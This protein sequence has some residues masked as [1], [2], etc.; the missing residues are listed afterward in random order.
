M[1]T[2]D[3]HIGWPLLEGDKSLTF[4]YAKKRIS[5]DSRRKGSL[6]N[7][8]RHRGKG[9]VITFAPTGAGKGVSTIIPTLLTYPGSMIVIDPKGEN[10]HVTARYRLEIGQRVH[11]LDPFSVV[12]PYRSTVRIGGR[13]T[14]VLLKADSLNPLDFPAWSKFTNDSES[15]SIA[16]SLAERTGNNAFWDNLATMLLTGLMH[17]VATS[18]DFPKSKRTLSSVIKM[19]YS[20]HFTQYLHDILKYRPID[21]Y[22][23]RAFEG[24]QSAGE[25]KTKGE[26]LSFARGYLGALAS[27]TIQQSVSETTIDIRGLIAGS[28]ITIYVVF[29]AS[30]LASFNKL[31]R[32]WVTVFIRIILSRNIVPKVS[33]LLLL[34]ECAQLGELEEIRTAVTLLRGY[35]LRA[36]MFYQDLSQLEQRY[37]DWQNLVNNCELIQAFGLSRSLAAEPLAKILG[38][39]TA[40]D[41]VG[42]G[43]YHQVISQYGLQPRIAE[44][45][46]YWSDPVFHGRYDPNPYIYSKN[47]SRH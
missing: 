46:T 27:E 2:S 15:Q 28:P 25:A 13:P 14:E 33:T 38:K 11:V 7:A 40:D 32:L 8:V 12:T 42:L 30:K 10:F 34:D 18:P 44:L 16:V 26:I 4:L 23:R 19:L 47:N 1:I 43:R 17:Y 37:K 9:H 20:E 35:G 21:Q 39:Y 31:L 45:M 22:A 36:W 24:Y 41:L 6:E 3:L 5:D 29:P